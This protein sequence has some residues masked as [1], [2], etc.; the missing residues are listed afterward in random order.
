VLTKEK[1]AGRKDVLSTRGTSAKEAIPV[2]SGS[3]SQILLMKW[4]SEWRCGAV[5]SK[6]PN[7][8]PATHF[9]RGDCLIQGEHVNE[10]E[11]RLAKRQGRVH[12]LS[13]P[14]LQLGE[15]SFMALLPRQ[16]AGGS[17]KATRFPKQ[18]NVG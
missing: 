8:M 15:M 7:I 2:L 1:I 6:F 4:R 9:P 12:I 3:E 14:S 16:C 17:Y 18:Y 11:T 13:N 5:L 10:I